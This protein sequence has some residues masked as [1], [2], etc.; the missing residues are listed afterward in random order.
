[1]GFISIV[2]KGSTANKKENA[3]KVDIRIN[4]SI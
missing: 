3:T 2:V 4:T 1:M